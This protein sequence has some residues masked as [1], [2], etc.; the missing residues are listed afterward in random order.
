MQNR[1]R[2][3]ASLSSAAATLAVNSIVGKF[4]MLSDAAAAPQSAT[5]TSRGFRFPLESDPHVRTFMQW[6]WRTDIHGRAG[7]IKLQDCLERIAQSISRFEDVVM[8]VS[9]R[10]VT[11][12]A[13]R[14]DKGS[15]RAKIE[16]WP[17]DVDDLWCRDAGPSFVLTAAGQKAVVDLGFNGWGGKQVH[18]NDRQLARR[19]AAKLGLEVFESG[20][21][22]EG[23]AVESDGA[24]TL[25][26]HESSWVN[27]NRNRASK[28][29]IETKLLGA[30]G[31]DK[32]IWAPGIAGADIT[33]YH[34]DALARFVKPG[35]V[36]IQLGDRVDRSDPWSV[37][38]F[39]T[40]AIL[41]AARDAAG[42]KLD[43]I[44]LKEP[45]FD[46][47]RSRS[48]SFVASYVNYYVCNGGVVT[49]EFG[50]DTA[51]QAA[52][53]TFRALYPERVVVAINTDALGEAGGG[54]HCATQQE[55]M[56]G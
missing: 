54:V 24:G 30:L 9:P 40:Y 10:Q 4:G 13:R 11:E 42:R 31:A 45:R 29:E 14:F 47:I 28:A 37:A 19:V 6:P 3:L 26:A 50:D 23:G 56:A 33:D 41:K 35:L 38:A 22:G 16:I 8:L 46:R 25:M 15:S 2:F 20:L 12:V 17:F 49:A 18:G 5:A 48:E 27:P 36:A 34:I 43:F 1:R 32:M 55:P 39:E 21:N 52:A 53:D 44:V 7:L 51:D